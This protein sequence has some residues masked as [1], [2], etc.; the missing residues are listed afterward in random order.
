MLNLSVLENAIDSMQKIVDRS[1]D[2]E[3]MSKQDFITIN[4]IQSGVIQHFE[5][6]Y[7]LCWKF[8]QRWIKENHSPEEADYPRTRKELFRTAAR[9]GLI[10]DPLPWFSYGDARNMTTHT[11]DESKARQVY[12]ISKNLVKDAMD[13]LNRL[14][15][16][17]VAS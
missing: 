11:Y 13:L 9:L 14:K 8:M 3:F 6:V 5:I 1:N 10:S 15:E 2:I 17:N 16:K 4:A 12:E 7:E